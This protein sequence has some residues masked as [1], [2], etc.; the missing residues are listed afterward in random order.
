M[1]VRWLRN[2]DRKVLLIAVCRK[3]H[4][5]AEAGYC[6]QEGDIQWTERNSLVYP[7]VSSLAGLVAGMFGV[8]GGIVKV[9]GSF[10]LTLTL[11]DTCGWHV[12][13]GWSYC[14]GMGPIFCCPKPLLACAAEGWH[15]C[16]MCTHICT[17]V[18]ADSEMACVLLVIAVAPFCCTVSAELVFES[19]QLSTNLF[20]Q[21]VHQCHSLVL[22]LVYAVSTRAV[23]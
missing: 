19:Q 8:G 18:D 5:Q 15:L 23:Q 10:L 13:G 1:T 21:H 2:T 9:W 14:Q 12:W 11:L 20:T 6:W 7:A 4:R 3:F 17:S 22:L 16:V